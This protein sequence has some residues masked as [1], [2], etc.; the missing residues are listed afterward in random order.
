MYATIHHFIRSQDD[1]TAP[2][3]TVIVVN[4]AIS[5]MIAPGA[6]AYS[7]SKYVGQRLVEYLDSGELAPML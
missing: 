2:Q 3:G 6:S 4:S 5:G 7:T 1:P